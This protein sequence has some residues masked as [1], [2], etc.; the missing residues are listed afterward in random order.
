MTPSA[1][2]SA[3]IDILAATADLRVPVAEALKDW[4]RRNRYAGAKDRAAIA[5]LVYDA[6]RTR[7]S[8]AWLM[9]ADTARDIMLGALKRARGLDAE[10]IAAL[11]SGERYA[12]ASLSAQERAR[13]ET[14]GLEDAPDHV[15]GDYPEWLAPHFA[16]V[17]GDEAAAEGRALARRAPVDLRVNPLK[18]TREKALEELAHLGPQATAFSPLGLRIAVGGDGRGPALSAEPAYVR[19][20]VEVQDE[21]S[22]IAALLAVPRPGEQAL[23]LC[24]GGGGKTLALAGLM[25]NSGQI[26]ATD[27]DGRR[28]MPIYER[29]E[30]S[31]ARNVQ[32]RA[33]R[34]KTDILED[35]EGRC[36]L[37]FVDAPC[38]GVGAW[39]RNP[40][41]K[42]RIRP[43][44]LEQRMKDQDEV[45]DRAARYVK[46]GGRL[47]YVT[48]S[49]LREENEDRVAAFLSAHPGFADP[50]MRETARGAGLESLV[51][52]AGFG[53]HGMVLRPSKIG[54]DGFF[55]CVLRRA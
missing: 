11:C 53:A 37:V 54:A 5:S 27:A 13:L 8:A 26:Y 14:A 10:A 3:A 55:V 46:P 43:G 51:A 31:G 25:G 17:F 38:T 48:C 1:R 50:D 16:R 20:L 40:D 42:W 12:P 22:Q 32:V 39:R 33:P 49:L 7:A 36:D 2:L 6:L 35:L 34:G 47:V 52:I 45:L 21:S 29:L 18:T 19:G 30:R 44:A 23:D 9:G 28:L 24:A 4:G 41:A 15:M